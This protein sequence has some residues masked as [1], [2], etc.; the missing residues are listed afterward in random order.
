MNQNALRDRI[1]FG[2]G[3]NYK[4]LNGNAKPWPKSQNHHLGLRWICR[5]HAYLCQWALRIRKKWLASMHRN[6][7]PFFIWLC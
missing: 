7:R 3:N 2:L 6:G 5:V 1:I 4:R